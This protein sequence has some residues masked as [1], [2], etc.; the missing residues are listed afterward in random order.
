MAG[1][2]SL[3]NVVEIMLVSSF[4]KVGFPLK[5]GG[6]LARE[7]SYQEVAVVELEDG[8]ISLKVLMS[9][10]IVSVLLKGLRPS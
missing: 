2:M 8:L 4:Y 9:R 1:E 10:P 6:R 7:I 3:N 5:K